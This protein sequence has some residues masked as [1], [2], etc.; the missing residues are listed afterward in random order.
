MFHQH[1]YFYYI[2]IGLDVICILHSI[3]NGTQNKWMLL[4]VFAPIV[5]ALVYLFAEVFTRRNRTGLQE[6]IS[7]ILRDQGRRLL[8]DDAVFPHVPVGCLHDAQKCL[9]EATLH[10]GPA[11]MV[12]QLLGREVLLRA[13]GQTAPEVDAE[14]PAVRWRHASVRG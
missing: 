4:I 5:G 11:R 2:T 7:G 12:E 3:R 9:P 10:I 14:G 6:G 8:D 1:S 13:D